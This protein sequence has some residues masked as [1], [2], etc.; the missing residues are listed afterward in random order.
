M[1]EIVKLLEEFNGMFYEIDNIRSFPIDLVEIE[2]GYRLDAEMPGV[3]KESIDIT[4]EDGYLYISAERKNKEGKYLL[5]ELNV[6]KYKRTIYFGNIKEESISAKLD[7]GILSVTI[8]LKKP[9]EKNKKNI[10][11]E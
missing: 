5:K 10:L 4:F 7:N 1:K 9:E 2:N 11:V 8:I 6:G 3:A